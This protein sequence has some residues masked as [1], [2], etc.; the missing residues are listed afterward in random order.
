[1]G[2]PMFGTCMLGRGSV[3][4][5]NTTTRSLHW[6]FP[7]TTNF[8]QLHPLT[9]LNGEHAG[10]SS[11]DAIICTILLHRDPIRKDI[12]IEVFNGHFL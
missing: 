2:M 12:R 10:T 4:L 11:Q 9:A 5:A 8:W 3:N 7:R 1:M 6:H